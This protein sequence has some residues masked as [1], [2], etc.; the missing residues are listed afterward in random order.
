MAKKMTTVVLRPCNKG[1]NARG[2]C[3]HKR[4]KLAK[5][6]KGQ[7]HYG[8]PQMPTMNGPREP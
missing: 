4:T 1:R 3:A 7:R 5:R 2:T 8:V 6:A